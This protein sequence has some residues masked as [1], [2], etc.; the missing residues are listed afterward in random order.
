[1][2]PCHPFV[3][4]RDS[5]SRDALHHSFTWDLSQNVSRA[6]FRSA[7]VGVCGCVTPGGELLLPHK[8]RT[9]MGYEKLLLQGIP[10]SRLLL[11][12]ESE[13]QL[14]DLAGNA[15]S[16]TVVCA[17]MLAAICAPQ[18]RR[19]VDANK[20]ASLESFSLSQKYDAAQGAVLA[21]RGDLYNAERDANADKFIDVF[22]DI[23]KSL[24]H[25]A[26]RSSVLCTC[27][28]SGTTTKSHRILECS[29]CGWAVCHDCFDRYQACTHIL[30]E[31]DASGADG[32][33]DPHVFERRL[34]CAVPSTLRLGKGWEKSIKDGDGLESYSFQ[35][36]QVDRK[37]GHWQLTYGAWEDHGSSRQV[38]ELR[39]TI[40]RTTTLD[41]KI[42]YAS[43]LRCFAPAIR[44]V[45]PHR[46]PLNDAARLV[47][48]IHDSNDMYPRWEVPA[49]SKNCTL[50]LIGSGECPS[51]RVL[52]GLSDVAAKALAAHKPMKKFL[53]PI[54]SRNDLIKY[55]KKWKTWPKTIVVSAD[56]TGRVNGRYNYAGCQHTVVLSALWRREATENQ[57]PMYLFFRPDVIRTKLDVAVISPTPSY[58]DGTEICELEDWIPENA[59]VESTHA[60]KAKFLRWDPLPSNLQLEIPTP[61]MSMV[62]PKM[63]FH[64]LVY[65][66]SNDVENP[67][68]NPVLCEMR[69][70]S[71]D[72]I[73][74]LLEYNDETKSTDISVIDLVGRSGPRNSKRLSIIAAPS[75]LKCAAQGQL[76]LE[77]SK[78]YRLASSSEFGRCPINV[79][80]RPAEQWRRIEG[81]SDI[82]V[83]RFYDAEASNEFFRVSG[84]VATLHFIHG[85]TL[86]TFIHLLLLIT[87]ESFEPPRSLS[88]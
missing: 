6:P 67:V 70:L 34:R 79:P 14:S 58:A 16:V 40:G 8:G 73:V 2:L 51:Q 13:V 76:P 31:I 42:G 17:T 48:Q 4:V 11:G 39:V 52:A 61:A 57:P 43:Y 20:K 62:T 23:A 18:L 54:A 77:L 33:P 74:S 49:P 44:H 30:E 83:E 27:E 78:W 5:I 36:Q 80:P 82:T 68:K 37:K 88:S 38:A 75:L 55:H 87:S 29:R 3:T 53:P 10:F 85:A 24:A 47:Y 28:S 86:I 25:D 32:R 66:S 56:E 9:V 63:P 15:M 21:E 60:T 1:M 59:L 41:H 84:V 81:K 65:T 72:V 12:P 50:K 71:K 22:M 64:D 46:G 45:K 69:G 26:F 19:Q 7:D 35:L